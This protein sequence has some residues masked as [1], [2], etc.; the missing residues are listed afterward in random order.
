[1]DKGIALVKISLHWE[2][3]ST[4]CANVIP[5]IFKNLEEVKKAP[6]Q[7]TTKKEEKIHGEIVTL[8]CNYT[9]LDALS[10]KVCPAYI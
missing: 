1:M 2:N 6:I 8:R 7:H 3:M 4:L 5:F 10:Q 9:Y